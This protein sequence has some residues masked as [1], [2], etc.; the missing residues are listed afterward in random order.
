[1]AGFAGGFG[2]VEEKVDLSYGFL[3]RLLENDRGIDEFLQV[4][5][6]TNLIWSYFQLNLT[7]NEFD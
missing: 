1:V 4:S 3:E 5:Q 2:Y 6:A 7:Q